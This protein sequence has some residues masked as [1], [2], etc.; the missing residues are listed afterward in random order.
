M[1]AIREAIMRRVRGPAASGLLSRLGVNPRQF[2]L[3]TDLFEELSD[4]EEILDQLGTSGVA[5]KFLAYLYFALSALISVML[6]LAQPSVASYSAFIASFNAFFLLLVL[7]PETANSLV[8]PVEGLVLAHQPINGATY[9]A[10]KL[11]RLARIIL[12]L[13]P[14]L[15]VIPA[16]AGLALTGSGWSYPLLFMGAAFAIGVIDALLCCALFGWLIRFMPTRRLK[17]AAQFIGILPPLAINALQLTKNAIHIVKPLARSDISNWLLARPAALWSMAAMLA[18]ATAAAVVFG[19]RSL[20]ADYLI[21][22]SVLMRGG[23]TAGSKI[24]RSPIAGIVA[25]VFGG[26]AARAGYAFVSRMILRDWQFRRTFIGMGVIV[27][28]G[29]PMMIVSGWRTDPFSGQFAPMYFLPHVL[30]FLLFL[31]CLAM[32]YGADYKGAWIFLLA[33]SGVLGGFARG[34]FALLWMDIVVFPNLILFPL[35]AWSWGI[36]HAAV[37][38]AFSISAASIYLGTEL[39][40]IE[41]APFS[42]QMD[43]LRGAFV[44]PV[45]IMGGIVMAIAVLAQYLLIFRSPTIAL[46]TTC[47]L[48]AVASLVTRSSLERWTIAI[49]YNLAVTSAETGKLFKEVGV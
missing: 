46:V 6:V 32:P 8:N 33:P 24:R 44:M 16:L 34:A 37:F 40:L 2:W 31:I 20:S 22:V 11:A 3:L 15:N 35:L 45:M 9:T 10:A 18:A 4:R 13:V 1:N 39:N 38:I 41:A 42:R 48:G 30:G 27:L 21:R 19:I 7:L 26:Q 47:G 12:Y 36:A 49:R 23:S 25:A 43:P 14:G 17:A 29:L 28:I 5:L